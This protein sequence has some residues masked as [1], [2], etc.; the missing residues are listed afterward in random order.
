MTCWDRQSP[1]GQAVPIREPNHLD[2]TP[3]RNPGTEPWNPN[4]EPEQVQERGT[5]LAVLI[6]RQR[7]AAYIEIRPPNTDF[8]FLGRDESNRA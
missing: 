5:P 4:R 3:E 8:G 2:G 1:G 6:L 7:P